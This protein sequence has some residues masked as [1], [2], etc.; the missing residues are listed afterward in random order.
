MLID[1]GKKVQAYINIYRVNLFRNKAQLPPNIVLHGLPI[2]TLKENSRLEIGSNVVLC[3][4]SRFTA[5]GVNHPVILR[6]L[7]DNA[8][9][10][11]GDDTGISGATICA[12]QSVSIGKECL[13]GANV[14]IAD[15]DFHPID[16]VNRRHSDD[17][18]RISTAPVKI[19][20]NVF[21]G[22]NSVILKGV[23]IGDN[24]VIGAGSVVITNIP[25]NVIAAGN[26]AKVIGTV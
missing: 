11:I 6:T 12:S 24:S 21:I 18:T 20:D 19:G 10:K 16:K 25:E 17:V 1:I 8:V 3:S 14:I 26:P 15:T 4:D 13:I 22:V 9:I 2:I 7:R 5:L 23:A